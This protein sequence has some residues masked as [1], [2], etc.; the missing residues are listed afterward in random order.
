MDSCPVT[1]QSDDALFQML[2]VRQTLTEVLLEVTN[3]E[4]RAVSQEM[5]QRYQKKSEWGELKVQSVFLLIILLIYF[6]IK[7][8]GETDSHRRS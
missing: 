6:R 7:G 5:K 1:V 2:L 8:K 3:E 4:I